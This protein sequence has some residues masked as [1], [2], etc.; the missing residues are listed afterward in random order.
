MTAG[1]LSAGLTEYVGYL[2][3]GAFVQNG[4]TN[5]VGADGLYVGFY[6][7]GTY[8]QTAEPSR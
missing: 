1:G 7:S 2:G 4:G 5:A 6:G 8:V 3:T